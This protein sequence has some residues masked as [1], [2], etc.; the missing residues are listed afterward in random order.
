MIVGQV[1]QRQRK[2]PRSAREDGGEQEELLEV[3][4]RE[5]RVS[6]EP[7]QSDGQHSRDAEEREALGAPLRGHAVRRVREQAREQHCDREAVDG[8]NDEQPGTDRL[9]PRIQP[10]GEHVEG[11][12]DQDDGPAPA[13]VHDVTDRRTRRDG[14]DPG[15]A[16]EQPDLQIAGAD[17]MEEARHVQ[18]QAEGDALG[19]VREPAE[20][21]GPGEEPRPRRVIRGPA[22]G[23]RQGRRAAASSNSPSAA[24]ARFAKRG[25]RVCPRW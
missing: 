5:D 21:E 12:S 16:R 19:Q 20:H 8:T 3:P 6:D 18:E 22:R 4:A 24:A 2:E 15:N 10:D 14:G 9:D 25:S 7:P 17:P 11:V 1:A 13:G 23:H